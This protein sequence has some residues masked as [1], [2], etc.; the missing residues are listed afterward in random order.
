MEMQEIQDS[1]NHLEKKKKK[2]VGQPSL[3]NFKSDHKAIFMKKAQHWHRESHNDQ[4]DRISS[5]KTNPNT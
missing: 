3:P 1:Q 5:S 4:W 2:E